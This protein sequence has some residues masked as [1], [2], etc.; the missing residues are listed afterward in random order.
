MLSAQ[1]QKMFPHL[2]KMLPGVLLGL[3]LSWANIGGVWQ[4]LEDVSYR[5]LF[6]VRGSR[7]WDDRVVVIEIDDDSLNQLGAFPWSR[8]R[9]K[10]L[11]EHLTPANPSVIAFDILLSESSRDDVGL[12]KAMDEYQRVVMPLAW[13]PDQRPIFPS[14][15]LQKSLIGMG[16]IMTRSS[17]D[18]IARSLKPQEQG[19][20]A[21]GIAI[22]QAHMVVMQDSVQL[23]LGNR[24]LWLNWQGPTSKVTRYSFSS[25]LARDVPASAFTDKIVLVGMTTTGSDALQMPFD[26][27]LPSSGV[28]FHVTVLNNILQNT[29]LQVPD[30]VWIWGLIPLGA[31]LSWGLSRWQWGMQCAVVVGAIGLWM[32][33]AVVLMHLN[34]WIPVVAPCL[35][36][37]GVGGI[38]VVNDRLRMQALLQVRSEFLAV[39]SHELRTPLNGILGMTDL[40]LARTGLDSQ[41]RDY[42]QTIDRS[43]EMLLGLINDVLDFAKI[44]AGK[45]SL[46]TVPFD[47]LDEVKLT[48]ALLEAKAHAKAIGLQYSIQSTIESE[49]QLG[50]SSALLG[51]GLRLRQV[52]LNLLG[53]AVK[54]TDRGQVRLDVTGSIQANL[55]PAKHQ[56]TKH[57][58]TQPNPV[59]SMTFRVIDSGIG[60]SKL[61]IDR[62]FQPFVQAD[63]SIQ[64][65]YGGTGLGLVISQQLVSQMGGQLQVTSELGVGSVF[66]F[67]L[68]FPV[69]PQVGNELNKSNE[70]SELNP[71][72]PL[73]PMDPVTRSPLKILLA[74][75][76]LINQKVI[77]LQLTQLGYH[78]DV[79]TDGKAVLTQIK[80]QPYDLILMDVQM[81]KLDGLAVTQRI[82]SSHEAY[83]NIHIMAMTAN[84]SESAVKACLEAGMNDVLGKPLRL[85]D[86]DAKLQAILPKI[87]AMPLNLLVSPNGLVSLEELTLEELTSTGEIEAPRVELPVRPLPAQNWEE[88]W[89]TLMQVTLNNRPLAIELLQ[90]AVHENQARSLN[91]KTAQAQKDYETLRAIAHQIR[92]SHGNLGLSVLTELAAELESCAM[93]NH[94]MNRSNGPS[95]DRADH[96]ADHSAGHSADRQAIEINRILAAMTIAIQELETFVTEKF[97]GAKIED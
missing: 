45:L 36:L 67:T 95:D 84:T 2:R 27:N 65:R 30:P 55:Q 49:F 75:D 21:F 91:L 1:L 53:N 93:M 72:N 29:F 59:Y 44:D 78:A 68:D 5:V 52:L 58:Q 11:I 56:P 77:L 63:S 60:M 96:S 33:I 15:V 87:S 50:S 20:D 16:H 61:Q 22:A 24:P 28:Y 47:L 62:L 8:K 57:Q 85:G 64:R 12:A 34:V 89:K 66:E 79:V 40:L 3:G 17:S 23:P 48:I 6:Q 14:P 7:S 25:V 26:R 38:A 39:M 32:G 97:P 46:E 37:G 18:G 86:L 94:S 31:L 74:E 76:N 81:P 9:Y 73:S 83:Q 54:F 80:L 92:G 42:I 4:T 19:V 70:W 88:A 13:N 90:L 71:L 82:R 43:G 10:Q 51:D 35:L 69:V 41:D